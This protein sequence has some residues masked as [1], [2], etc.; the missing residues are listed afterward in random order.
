MMS[1]ELIMKMDSECHYPLNM[2]KILILLNDKE[3]EIDK[4][5]CIEE[6]LK[7]LIKCFRD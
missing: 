1:E 2:Y 7:I 3:F 4:I 6:E 5:E